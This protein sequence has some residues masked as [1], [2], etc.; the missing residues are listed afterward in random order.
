MI[1]QDSPISDLQ[2]SGLTP[3]RA[4]TI[5]TSISRPPF[6][7]LSTEDVLPFDSLHANDQ[8]IQG[9]P[10]EPDALLRVASPDVADRET[11]LNLAR[12]SWDAYHPT[13]TPGN[14]HDIHGLNWVRAEF[15][16]AV[17]SHN[18]MLLL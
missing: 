8:Q 5:I 1:L 3:L 4:R 15:G 7:P 18:E 16:H 13:P 9:I 6:G 10:V 17:N 14:W 2:G 12:A 11:L